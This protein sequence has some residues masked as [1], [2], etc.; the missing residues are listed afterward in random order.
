MN[1]IGTKESPMVQL[2]SGM[3][4]DK[5]LQNKTLKMGNMM[6]FLSGGMRMDR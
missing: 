2:L 1:E 6:G 4:M 3:E 5:D